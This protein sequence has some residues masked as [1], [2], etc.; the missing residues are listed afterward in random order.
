MNW[1]I[2]FLHNRLQRVKLNDNC[3]CDWLEV[4]AGVPQGTLLVLK[5]T[6]Y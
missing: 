2:D 5:F 1:I 6:Q 4:A 3:F